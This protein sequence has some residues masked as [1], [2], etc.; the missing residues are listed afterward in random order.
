VCV[1]T[2]KGCVGHCLIVGR[3]G[4]FDLLRVWT[5]PHVYDYIGCPTP[6]STDHTYQ[7]EN[8]HSQHEG[9]SPLS[10]ILKSSSPEQYHNIIN[11]HN[12]TS[13]TTQTSNQTETKYLSSLK[14][15]TL[16]ARGV[17]TSQHASLKHMIATN[18]PDIMVLT[19]TKLQKGS[20]PQP[21]LHQLLTN[22]KWCTS[23]NTF[24]G[25]IVCVRKCI[26]LATNCSLAHSDPEGRHTSVIRN[27]ADA[28]LLI[29]GN[30]WPSGPDHKH[31]PPAL[32]CKHKLQPL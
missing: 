1:G 31:K 22:Y 23:T 7:T 14:I 4:R 16:N 12:H 3:G 30:Y 5:I 10:S 28:N 8:T 19:E 27:T 2:Q 29:I 24:G 26:A 17:F 20:K 9:S 15:L 21:W 32:R 25:T 13:P 18:T 6:Q 11:H